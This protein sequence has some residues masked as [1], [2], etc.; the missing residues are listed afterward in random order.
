MYTMGVGRMY[1]RKKH[2]SEAGFLEID[3]LD[4]YE[5]RVLDDKVEDGVLTPFEAGFLRE[6]NRADEH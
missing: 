4:L 5:D 2:W 3:D 6:W 1:Q